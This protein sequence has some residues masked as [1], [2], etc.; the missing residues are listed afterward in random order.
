MDR[1][2]LL[3]VTSRSREWLKIKSYSRGS[4]MFACP[5]LVISGNF[6]ESRTWSL[7]PE[8]LPLPF[9]ASNY[10]S[11]LPVGHASAYSAAALVPPTCSS[12]GASVAV[13]GTLR[14]SSHTHAV[15]GDVGLGQ[16]K[17]RRFQARTRPAMSCQTRGP[18]QYPPGV[19]AAM[20]LPAHLAR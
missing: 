2:G 16:Q 5:G 19:P 18:H 13:W 7:S 17:T 12:C 11:R 14:C 6:I 20:T 1:P 9:P 4:A 15:G 10:S 8:P 3:M